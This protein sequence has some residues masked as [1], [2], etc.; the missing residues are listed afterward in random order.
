MHV[1]SLLRIGTDE[2]T[3]RQWR[4]LFSDLRY[5]DDENE[6]YEPWQIMPHKRQVLIPRGA[7]FLLPDSVVYHDDLVRP[8]GREFDFIAELDAEGFSGQ[9]DALRAMLAQEQGI[10]IGQPG[11]G[12][13]DV[14]LAFASCCETPTLILVHTEDILQ[15]SLDRA[16]AIVPD[17]KLGVIRGTDLEIGDITVA[18]V[19]TFPKRLQLKGNDQLK[20]AFGCVILDEAHHAPASTFDEI[21][22]KMPAY[23]RFGF[24]A[25]DKRADKKHPYMA[26]VLGPVIFRKKFK[27]KV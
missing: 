22:N 3:E 26:T 25:T 16:A 10:V 19:Q 20:E 5:M 27:S 18:T 21:L 13:T 6:I 9:K 17:A 12:K 8:A 1:D 23:F 14:A 2:L 11:F 24:T 15:Q 7:W 4:R